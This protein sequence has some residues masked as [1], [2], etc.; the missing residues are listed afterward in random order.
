M[1]AYVPQ[2]GAEAYTVRFVVASVKRL[3]Y[4]KTICSMTKKLLGAPW[5]SKFKNDHE[6][7]WRG[8]CQPPDGWDSAYVVV[9][10]QGSVP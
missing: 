9:G 2:T 4:P 6:P 3:G 10:S 5:W 8:E 7:R 1:M